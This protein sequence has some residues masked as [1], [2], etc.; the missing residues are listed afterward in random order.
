MNTLGCRRS[1]FLRKEGGFKVEGHHM[2]VAGDFEGLPKNQFSAQNGKE[3][4]SCMEFK[5]EAITAIMFSGRKQID[6]SLI[7]YQLQQ[8]FSTFKCA[9]ID[10]DKR[11]I[12]GGAAIDFSCRDLKGGAINCRFGP[13]GAITCT[14]ASKTN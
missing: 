11:P 12:F 2:Q 5:A 8:K 13:E 3:Q 6:K 1:L 14:A 7:N 4:I 10:L 9:T